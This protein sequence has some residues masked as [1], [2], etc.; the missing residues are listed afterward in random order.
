MDLEEAEEEDKKA[1]MS[2]GAPKAVAAEE[3]LGKQTED[4]LDEHYY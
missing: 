1:K 2:N 3:A 4:I